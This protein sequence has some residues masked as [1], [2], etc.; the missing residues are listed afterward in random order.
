MK[1]A[2][3]ARRRSGLRQQHLAIQIP[4]IVSYLWLVH[5]LG[6]G[7]PYFPVHPMCWVVHDTHTVAGGRSDSTEVR[8]RRD[9]AWPPTSYRRCS[10][11]LWPEIGGGSRW[12]NMASN[13][14]NIRP[15][16]QARSHQ[17]RKRQDPRRLSRVT[18]AT[19][20]VFAAQNPEKEGG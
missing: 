13:P 1:P 20:L 17:S 12:R 5:P 11:R 14:R 2:I 16:S 6:S 18:L 4:K 3:P 15:A 19:K 8:H 9:T 7:R 10:R